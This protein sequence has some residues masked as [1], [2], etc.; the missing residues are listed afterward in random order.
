MRGLLISILIPVL[1]GATPVAAH[2]VISANE[3]L[4]PDRPE[5]WA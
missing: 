3:K 5:A 1:L 2:T 4:A